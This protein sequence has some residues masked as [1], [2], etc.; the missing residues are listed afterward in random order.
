MILLFSH[1]FFYIME[2]AMK[3]LKKVVQEKGQK[4]KETGGYV[5]P[6]TSVD[7]YILFYHTSWQPGVPEHVYKFKKTLSE[8]ACGRKV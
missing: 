8:K 2:A 3:K 6:D 1:S 4:N 7:E 5:I